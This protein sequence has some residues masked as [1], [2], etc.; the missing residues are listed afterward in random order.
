MKEK[1]LFCINKTNEDKGFTMV[2]L[3]IVIAI[4]GI[5]AQISVTSYVDYRAKAFN[6]AAINDGRQLLNATM[7]NLV[8]LDDVDYAHPENGGNRIGA[9]DTSG[10]PREPILFLSPSVRARITGDNDTTGN[11]YMEAHLYSVG[12]TV[13]PATHSGKREYYCLVDEASELSYFS[14]D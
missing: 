10:N 12:G 14:L 3:L 4:I 7:N 8:S 13:D 2:E 11:G 1:L 6:T 5:L 9:V